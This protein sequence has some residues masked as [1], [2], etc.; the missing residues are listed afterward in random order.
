VAES[1]LDRA[2]LQ[3]DRTRERVRQRAVQPLAAPAGAPPAIA[4]L[5]LPLSAG[6][7][8]EQYSHFT[9]WI[10]ASIRP[11]A[12]RISGQP[13]RV[14][15]RLKAGKGPAGVKAATLAAPAWVKSLTHDLEVLPSHPLIDTLSDPNSVMVSWSLM[16]AT[17][18]SLE[19]TGRSYWWLYQS[20][21]TPRLNS[22]PRAGGA[23]REQIW[24]LPAS[25]VRPIDT[26]RL[27][28]QYEVRPPGLTEPFLVDGEDMVAFSYPDP[29]NPLGAVSPLQT[30][31]RGVRADESIQEAQWRAFRNGI[32][33]DVAIVVGKQQEVSGVNARP[34]LT[35]QQRNDIVNAIKRRYAGVTRYG[36]PI[37][38]DALIEDIKRI[39]TAPREM[40]FLDS[41]KSS[42]ERITQGFGVNPVVMGQ[43]EGANRASAFAAENHF[44]SECVNPKIELISQCLSAWLC[45]RFGD[46]LV[47]WIEPAVAHDA[48]QTRLDREQLAR[49]GAITKNELRSMHGLPPL[50]GGDEFIQPRQAQTKAARRP[51]MGR[52]GLPK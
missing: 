14:A 23:A 40:D 4:G 22:A 16:Y 38:L 24:P 43:L 3:A 52:N 34:E 25:W 49:N 17:V 30:Q 47:C 9:G 36:E 41:G 11:I 50:P 5:P 13:V 29:S 20:P 32:N 18:A 51:R 46:D 15:R 33:P 31:A 19:L 37:I 1:S 7:A 45:P 48:E 42:K 8:R 26:D 21:T 2:F 12:Q 28:A 27:N 35:A 10:Y 39:S 6:T 44:V